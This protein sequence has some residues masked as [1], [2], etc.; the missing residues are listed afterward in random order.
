LLG[1]LQ[2]VACARDRTAAEAM[3]RHLQQI[4]ATKALRANPQVGSPESA[5]PAQDGVLSEC[6]L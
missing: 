1:A 6:R 4:G 2:S 5:L 3:Y